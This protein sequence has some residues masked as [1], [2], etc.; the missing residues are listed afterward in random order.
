MQ[1]TL[2]TPQ[3]TVD[4]WPQVSAMLKQA[5]DHGVGETNILDYLKKVL[6]NNAQ[7]WLTATDTGEVRGVGLTQFLQYANHKTLH[8][9]AFTGE[10]WTE[11]SEQF[12]T[13]EEF[14]KKHGAVACES[15]G[16]A[17]WSKV[18]PKVIPGF[19]V[20]YHVMRKKIE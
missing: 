16:R 12:N 10:G 3:Q 9:V 17:G 15:W 6:N 2:L 1:T 14:A 13:V 5:L 19:E 8:L 20:V 11:W 7:V 4:L 18:L